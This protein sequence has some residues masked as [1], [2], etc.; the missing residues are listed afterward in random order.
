MIRLPTT[1]ILLSPTDLENFET[2]QRR[3][4]DCEAEENLRVKEERPRT[5]TIR[6]VGPPSSKAS[7][8]SRPNEGL[9]APGI[10]TD[11]VDSYASFTDSESAEDQDGHLPM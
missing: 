4:R 3:R 8:G 10:L 9:R 6:T 5:L 2:R 11:T 1:A 7:L